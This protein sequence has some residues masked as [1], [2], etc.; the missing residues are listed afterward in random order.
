MYALGCRDMCPQDWGMITMAS[1][2]QY[3]EHNLVSS[4]TTQIK[5]KQFHPE[6]NIN[7]K[8]L[9]H[10]YRQVISILF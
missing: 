4:Q 5:A 2:M 7:Y 6:L 1:H 9:M 8:A 3:A 10:N